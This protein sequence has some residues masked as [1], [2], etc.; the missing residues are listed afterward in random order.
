M[1][2]NTKSKQTTSRNSD[3]ISASTQSLH[4]FKM[5]NLRQLVERINLLVDK[6]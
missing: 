3:V 5:F 2:P 1:N 6:Q 4:A